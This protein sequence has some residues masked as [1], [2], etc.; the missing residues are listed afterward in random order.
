MTRA[1]VVNYLSR[2]KFFLV[3][4]GCTAL[5]GMYE[6]AEIKLVADKLSPAQCRI[7]AYILLPR[8]RRG[9]VSLVLHRPIEA[10]ALVLLRWL[11]CSVEAVRSIAPPLSRAAREA[12]MPPPVASLLAALQDDCEVK[13]EV[14]VRVAKSVRVDTLPEVVTADDL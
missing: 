4:Q 1:E 5:A 3:D 11:L 14:A 2:L 12:R 9:R 13:G 7:Y 8:G 10:R 6:D